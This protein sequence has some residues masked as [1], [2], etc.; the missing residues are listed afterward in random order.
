MFFLE[1]AKMVQAILLGLGLAMDAGAVSMT[2]G[3]IEPKMKVHKSLLIALMFGLFQCIMPIIGYFAG[4]IFTAFIS[5]FTAWFALIL[6]GY[7]GGKMLFDGIKHLKNPESVK[8]K[9]ITFGNLCLQ[10]VATSIDAL[11]IGLI[12]VGHGTSNAIISSGIIG[13]VTFIISIACIY[14]GKHFGTKLSN[15][16]EIIGGVILIGIGIKIFIEYL[17]TIL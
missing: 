4:S 14:I 7:I 5:K 3:L 11:A 9:P 8:L 2:D 16:A 13:I 15:K 6:L 12:F 17:I 10:A 1:V